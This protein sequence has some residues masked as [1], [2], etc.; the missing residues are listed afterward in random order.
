MKRIKYCFLVFVLI[1]ATFISQSCS[2]SKIPE[3]GSVKNDARIF[4]K[5]ESGYVGDPIP[6]FDGEK[7]NVFYLHDSRKAGPFH[8]W[9]LFQTADFVHWEDKEEAIPTAK[10]L[11]EIAT[12]PDYALGTGSVI[13]DKQGLYHAFYTGWNNHED[14]PYTEKIQHAVSEDLINWTKIPEDGFYG[15]QDDFRDPYVF[16]DEYNS[17]YC[18]LITTRNNGKGVL[19]LYISDDLHY[20]SYDSIFFIND[21]GTYNLE[22]PTFLYWN[23]Y[24]YLTFSEQAQ[25]GSANRVTRYRYKKELSDDWIIPE[26]DYIDGAGFYAAKLEKYTDNRMLAFGWI[27]TKENDYDKGL[28][29]WAGNLAVHE[30]KQN[31]DGTIYADIVKEVEKTLHTEVKYNVV[32]GEKLNGKSVSYNGDKYTVFDKLETKATLMTFKISDASGILKLSFGGNGYNTADMLSVDM[33]FDNGKLLFYTEQDSVNVLQI[34]CELKKRDIYNC[35]LITC[36]ECITLYVNGNM[37][38][39]VRIYAMPNNNFGF[40]S[41]GKMDITDIVFYE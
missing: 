21:S 12:N 34:S 22:C 38:I 40:I 23:R 1:A 6:Y 14:F 36:G 7:M 30:I 18:M 35:K 8:P 17:R 26:T 27:P 20:W 16:Y 28:F 29:N 41:D 10:Y 4:V 3:K 19:K 31:T 9:Y 39:S 2:N 32:L 25:D 11:S 37:A 5:S 15:G 24:Y 33:D 13:K